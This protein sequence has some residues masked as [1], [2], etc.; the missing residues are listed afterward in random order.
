MISAV[1]AV[2]AGYRD[3]PAFLKSEG[4]RQTTC[5]VASADLRGSPAQ[6]R[7]TSDQTGL[8]PDFRSNREPRHATPDIGIEDP[9][10]GDR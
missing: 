7:L 1:Y 8:L 6:F 4:L 10:P 9:A 3:D 2:K 5:R